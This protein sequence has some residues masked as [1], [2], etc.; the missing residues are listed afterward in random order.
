MY[1]VIFTYFFACSD[2]SADVHCDVG[3]EIYSIGESYDAE[4]GCNTCTCMSDGEGGASIGCTEIGC[5]EPEP[6]NCADM[7]INACEENPICTVVYGSPIM[8]DTEN[9]CYAWANEV[10][11]LGCINADMDCTEGLKRAA[12]TDDPNN[13]YGF[14]GC[15]PEGW[16]ACGLGDYP[17][18]DQIQFSFA[19]TLLLVTIHRFQR[20]ILLKIIPLMT[21]GSYPIFLF[22]ECSLKWKSIAN[23]GRQG[24][25]QN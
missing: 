11:A 9:E 3:G 4:D 10:T 18:C 15:M 20:N 7:S 6:M 16:G 1:A 25:V 13:C 22:V 23:K 14:G 12:S 2:K 24:Y 21:H 8:L 5:G 19:S 17:D